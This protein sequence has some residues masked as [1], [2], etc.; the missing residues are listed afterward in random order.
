MNGKPSLLIRGATIVTVNDEHEV[1]PDGELLI[2][3]GL[4]TSVGRASDPPVG[5]RAAKADRI[6]DAPGKVVLPGLVNAH[7]HA[8]MSLLRG[9]AD[10]LPLMQWLQ[11][12]VWPVES[13]LVA[14]D[15]F[16][17]TALAV[18]EM[19]RGGVTTF[20]DMYFFMDKVAEVVKKVGVRAIIS[21]GVTAGGSDQSL[22]ETRKLVETWHKGA[23][24]RIRVAVG[25]HAPY[26]C[27][28]DFLKA[29]T[30]L[31]KELNVPLHTHVA[32]TRDETALIQERY[33]ATPVQYLERAGV[34]DA[35]RVTAAHCVHLSDEDIKILADRR[36]G[37]ASCPGSNLK[38]AAGIAP[39]TKMAAAGIAIGLGTD[40]PASVGALDMWEQMR[41]AAN[42]QKAVTGKADAVTAAQT[43]EMA[44]RGGARAL[45]LDGQIGAII[46]GLGADVI[47]VDIDKP[48][49]Y[50]PH[51][52]VSALVYAGHPADVETVIV[53]GEPVMEER[54]LLNVDEREVLAKSAEHA[55]R[56]VGPEAVKKSGAAA[57]GSVRRP[58]EVD[59]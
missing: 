55:R 41:L 45:G 51:D 5:W 12:R 18:V 34:F 31:A 58:P 9:Y 7:N 39:L 26:T 4:I 11:E 33:G 16:W 38:L 19:V 15:V 29:V 32:E 10:D 13:R 53:A 36:V 46:P 48:H 37:V 43:L 28:P 21:R 52:V 57:A 44:T 35:P 40:G 30:A 22:R 6:I 59:R 24:G 3:K 50:P 47:I 42:L 17:G 14:E 25:P 23:S 27:P 56:L 8:A 20:A 2:D 54:L 49:F 1:I